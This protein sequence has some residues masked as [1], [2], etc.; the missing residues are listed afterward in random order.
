MKEKGKSTMSRRSFLARGAAATSVFTIVP[1][2]VLG[3]GQTPP[4]EKLNV[5]AIGAGGKGRGDIYACRGENIVA[6]CDVDDVRAADSY[7]QFPDAK[8][9][10]DFR[11][12]LDE[13][14]DDIDAL[15]ISTADHTHAIAAL[16]CM[17]RGKH[18]YVQKPLT[19]SIY[20]ARLLTECARK[21]GVATQMGNQGH[22][23]DGVRQMCEMVWNGIIGPV[24]EAHIWTNRPVWPQGGADPDNLSEPLPEEPIPDSLKWDLFLG[25]A[26][27]RPFNKGYTPFNWRGWWDFGTGALG[28]MGCHIM[29][30]ANW[31]LKLCHPTSVEVITQRGRNE[32]TGP[33]QSVVKYEFPAREDMPELTLYWYEGGCLPPY[34]EGIPEGEVLGDGRN[35]S[36]F[37]GDDGVITTGEY[38]G[39]T[40]LLPVSKMQD[41]KMPE[42]SIPRI[43]FER[44]AHYMDWLTACKGGRPACS[45][46]DYAGP[47]TEVVLLGN[48]AQR[49]N[50]KLYWDGPNM[51]VTNWPEAN[52]WVNPPVREGWE[53]PFTI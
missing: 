9:F 53:Y 23:G 51:K 31:A 41:Y 10:H 20:E 6:L 44:D 16:H 29:D 25:P 21:Y 35:G 15:T 11:V 45:N 38:G 52:Q 28:D 8:R 49:A 2:H 12:M 22:S 42:P 3:Q 46:F 33:N 39:N 40:R 17:M 19:H 43:E 32:Q 26:P 18:V 1:R 13:M 37:V 5:A 7:A 14:G 47:F 34:P 27:Y 4:S 36:Y 50:R 24:R 48:L 30:P